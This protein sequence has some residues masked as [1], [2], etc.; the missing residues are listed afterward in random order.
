M[1][2][3]GVRVGPVSV[4]G[5]EP[6]ATVVV[7]GGET[8]GRFALVETSEE[9]GAEPPRH[10]HHMEGET[11]CVL[12]G[13]LDVWVAGEWIEVPAGAAVFLP[14][15]VEHAFAVASERARVLSLFVPAGFEGFYREMGA[16]DAPDVERLVVLAARYGCE[17]TGPAPE[18]YRADE[19]SPGSKTRVTGRDGERGDVKLTERE[20]RI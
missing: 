17:I 10:L 12:D 3:Y 15:G 18:R 14:R 4:P 6:R 13:S 16:A 2:E 5:Q 7:G 9:R 1:G 11:L 19:P 20:S 8:G